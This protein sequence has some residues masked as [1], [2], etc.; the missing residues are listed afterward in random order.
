MN[1]ENLGISMV[2]II[3]N[4]DELVRTLTKKIEKLEGD[5]I[6]LKEKLKAI[7]ELMFEVQTMKHRKQDLSGKKSIT[8]KELNKKL[9]LTIG[10]SVLFC[11]VLI[12]FIKSILPTLITQ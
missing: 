10:L 4:K 11:F 9:N 2:Q 1:N 7:V 6:A 8:I 5:K 12:I 3:K